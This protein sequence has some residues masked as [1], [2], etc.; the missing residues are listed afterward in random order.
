MTETIDHCGCHVWNRSWSGSGSITYVKKQWYRSYVDGSL[1]VWLRSIRTVVWTYDVDDDWTETDTTITYA[2]IDDA[3]GTTD[4]DIYTV[5]FSIIGIA[6]QNPSNLDASYTQTHT[7]KTITDVINWTG[8][9]EITYSGTKLREEELTEPWTEALIVADLKL[10][11]YAKD[12]AAGSCSANYEVTYSQKPLL[13]EGGEVVTE[14]HDEDP[15][16]A[17]IIVYEDEEGC[18]DDLLLRMFRYR[19]VIPD[20]FET[21]LW[22][23][24]W[25]RI[26]W[27]ET[28]TP[29]N[30]D[31]DPIANPKVVTPKNVEWNGAGTEIDF[32]LDGDYTAAEQ[33]AIDSWK[34]PWNEVDFP[35][36]KGSTTIELKRSQCYHGAPWV[37]H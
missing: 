6:G 14:D 28:F 12:W 32:D 9:A 36:V 2:D 5:S 15:E 25:H 21:E 18:V 24:T 30:Y 23:G 20:T 31:D 11:I 13:D 3:T 29:Y 16:T 7:H 33:T 27:E 4:V 19:I 34:T 8:G 26:E 37:Y 10:C 1:E 22:T 35:A 17:E